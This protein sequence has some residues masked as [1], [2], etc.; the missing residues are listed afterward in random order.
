MIVFRSKARPLARPLLLAAALTLPGPLCLA[1]ETPLNLLPATE[2][3]AVAP[4][5]LPAGELPTVGD[6]VASEVLTA[7]EG[8]SVGSLAAP[9]PDGAGLASAVD[10]GLPEGLWNGSK[11]DRVAALLRRL[12]GSMP[13]SKSMKSLLE[14]VALAQMRRPEAWGETAVE[15]ALAPN[16][17]LLA[18]RLELLLA[19]GKPQKVLELLQRVPR[20]QQGSAT[21]AVKVQALLLLGSVEEVCRITA[22][23]IVAFHAEAFWARLLIFCQVHQGEI[24]QGLLGLDILSDSGV[25]DRLFTALVYHLAGGDPEEAPVEEATALH[26]AIMHLM[27]YPVPAAFVEAAPAALWASLVDYGNLEPEMRLALAE[28][29]AAVGLIDGAVLA[30]L[31]AAFPLEEADRATLG[32]LAEP[33]ATPRVRAALYQAMRAQGYAI[34]RAEILGRLL[35]NAS[36]D[37]AW[38]AV[39]AAVLPDLEALQPRLGLAWFAPQAAR[40]FAASG[41]IER[42]AAWQQLAARDSAAASLVPAASLD[43]ETA[44][45]V[46]GSAEL[47]QSATGNRATG[48]APGIWPLNI[49]RGLPILP[50]DASRLTRLTGP[51]GLDPVLEPQAGEGEGI[52]TILALLEALEIDTGVGWDGLAAAGLALPPERFASTLA[53]ALARAVRDQRSGEGLILAA[54]LLIEAGPGEVGPV[55]A[56]QL[57]SGLWSLGFSD[58]ARGL[59]IELAVAQGY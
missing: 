24:D 31:Y 39:L 26:L 43:E 15:G 41:Q 25:E 9:D 7:P 54:L 38:F 57:I 30:D 51:L 36:L 55:A 16:D 1:Q 21:L 59:A 27:N 5:E 53:L 19:L 8:I 47:L 35:E 50:G 42:A 45:A 40:A 12:A 56:D 20:S 52:W 2:G 23:E 18:A 33:P 14:G 4:G 6:P 32:A 44:A 49:I 37:G 17:D 58:Q 46:L 29:S 34:S 28:R 3:E 13:V 10:Y 22:Q 11:R 48:G